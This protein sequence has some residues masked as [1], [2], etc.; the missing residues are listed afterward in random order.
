MPTVRLWIPDIG[1]HFDLDRQRVLPRYIMA[2]DVDFGVIYVPDQ[3]TNRFAI[4]AVAARAAYR[5]QLFTDKEFKAL[6]VK[7]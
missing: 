1:G 6:W 2:G 7:G 4:L 5:L 3:A